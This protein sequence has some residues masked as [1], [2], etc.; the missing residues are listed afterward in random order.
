MNAIDKDV[1]FSGADESG[2]RPVANGS[3]RAGISRLLSRVRHLDANTDAGRP[4]P[5]SQRDEDVNRTGLGSEILLDRVSKHFANKT[6]LNEIS[7]K[8][9]SGSFFALLGPSGSGKSTMLNLI[10]GFERPDSGDIRI[11]G[12]SVVGIPAYARQVGVVFQ[13]YALFPH[14]NVAENLAYPLRRQGIRSRV[15]H[16][17]VARMLELVRLGGYADMRITQLSGGQQQRVALARALIAEPDV[18]LMDEPMAALDKSLRD[19]LQVEIKQ[20]QQ[21]LGAT[22]IYITHDQ[23]EALALADRIGILNEGRFE[24]VD[25]AVN[26]YAKPKSAFVA[27]F[28]TG[29]SVL[30]GNARA[31]AGGE[32]YFEDANG[33]RLPG[34]WHDRM[35]G[36]SNVKAEMATNPAHVKVAALDGN[37]MTWSIEARVTAVLYV[38]E[39]TIVHLA[40]Q[41]GSM[42]IAREPGASRRSVGEQVRVGWRPED[43]SLFEMEIK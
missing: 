38:G 35:P 3:R 19:D 20:L 34:H 36:S 13:S 27:R 8:L 16:A 12:R 4:I 21:S 22:I 6:V 26:I 10:A 11:R 29:A 32:W 41:G 1:L 24:Q 40:L 7:L 2:A 5:A 31:S 42:L 43:A 30:K 14:L 18:L 25:D 28:L 23:R 33:V 37:P 17:R 39:S 15:I 9:D